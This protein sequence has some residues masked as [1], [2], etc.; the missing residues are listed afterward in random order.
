[1]GTISK[2]G[3]RF[4]PGTLDS[5]FRRNDEFYGISTLYEIITFEISLKYFPPPLTGEG[6]GGGE[7]KN[8][9]PL[10]PLM[11]RERIFL[12]SEKEILRL[13][14]ASAYFLKTPNLR[15]NRQD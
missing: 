3:S 13:I 2:T 8:H 11:Q 7:S 5:G 4:S 14:V 1:L 15:E 6:E 9:P 12:R 10:Y